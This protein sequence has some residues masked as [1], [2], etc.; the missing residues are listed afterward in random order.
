MGFDVQIQ[1][2]LESEANK[3]TEYDKFNRVD[4]LVKSNKE[5]LILIEL[6]HDSEADYFHRIFY[7]I[8][9]LVTQYISEG[10]SYGS[11]KKAYSINIVYFS[12]GEGN[13]Y[14]YEYR[15][16][17]FDMN[18]NEVL[19][20]TK[21]QKK[22][23]DIEAVSD[24]FPKYYIINVQNF[25]PT[26][27]RN[28]VEEWLY[29]LKKSEIPEHFKAKGIR[30]ARKKLNYEK[31]PDLERDAYKRFVENRRIEMSVKETAKVEGF[32]EGMEKGIEKGIEKGEDRKAIKVAKN[33]LKNNI[34]I[35]IIVSST[36]LSLEEIEKLRKE[37]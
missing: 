32:N 26:I 12:L 6:Q 22:K 30:K 28:A 9:K 34:D 29:F 20:P 19:Q 8:S 35:N 37:L 10:E 21:Y 36:G 3:E 5:E 31:M 16:E 27:V 7:G 4:I 17:F 14:L 11:I 2:I 33:L 24:I 1:E 15:G 18:S 13:T 25:Q 23:Y